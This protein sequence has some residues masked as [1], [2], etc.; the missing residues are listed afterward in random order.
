ML[1]GCFAFIA[2]V[3]FLAVSFARAQDTVGGP[4]EL[5]AGSLCHDVEQGMLITSSDAEEQ[6]LFAL[7]DD[8]PEL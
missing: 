8:E 2:I 4:D 1:Q 6:C 3:F 5:E 7:S